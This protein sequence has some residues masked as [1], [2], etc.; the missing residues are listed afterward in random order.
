MKNVLYPVIAGMLAAGYLVGAL[1]MLRFWTRTRD[2]LFALFALA[3]VVL[4]AQRVASVVTL[5]WTETAGWTYTLRLAAFLL[6][7][8]AVLDK[9]RPGRAGGA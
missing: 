6:I 2:R 1:F 8:G 5:V 7:L 3:F 9:N 4:A